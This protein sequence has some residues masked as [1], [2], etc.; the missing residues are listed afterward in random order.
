MHL[1]DIEQVIKLSFEDF[2]LSKAEKNSFKKLFDSIKQEPDKLNFIRNKAFEIVRDDF[3]S[4]EPKHTESLKWLE[5][6]IKLIDQVQSQEITIRNDVYFSPGSEPVKK[7]RS[8]IKHAKRSIEVCVFTISD[9]NITQSLLDAHQ[10]GISIRIVSD[11]D[12][13]DDLGSDIYRMNKKGI[14]IKVDRSANHMHHKFA[15]VDNKH[16]ISGSFNWTRSATHHNQENIIVSNDKD[17]IAQFSEQFELLW[18]KYKQ[19]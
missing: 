10:R 1:T 8:L 13:A 18:G 4:E 2:M 16:L 11:N 3:Y 9:D 7:I 19:L 17:L 5:E 6:I 15:I 14:P 12:K